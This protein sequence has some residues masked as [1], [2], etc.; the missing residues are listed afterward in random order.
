MFNIEINNEMYTMIKVSNA[1]IDL[2]L[3][4][5]GASI[6]SLKAY[7]HEF[8]LSPDDKT[9]FFNSKGYYGKTLGPIAGRYNTLDYGYKEKNIVLHGNENGLSFK[10]FD[11]EIKVN[12]S[13]ARV[14]FTYVMNEK[15]KDFIGNNAIF[16]VEYIL[17]H[18]NRLKVKHKIKAL[19][20]TYASMSS[21]LYFCLKEKDIRETY[22]N[23]NSNEVSIISDDFLINS[24]TNNLKGLN[25]KELKLLKN[26][27]QNNS[28]L[29]RKGHHYKNVKY[30]IIIKD[31]SYKIKINS[32][33]PDALLTI[34][35]LPCGEVCQ[36]EK[37]T[38]YRAYVIEP[39]I[40][41]DNKESLYIKKGETRIQTIEYNFKNEI[42]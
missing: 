37:E 27:L 7:N 12:N 16:I 17:N 13:Y 33:Y 8:L 18:S 15:E 14:I 32:T 20:N 5:F 38:K 34:D 11:Y 4:S 26:E 2:I 24:Y 25:F 3:S 1:D 35:Q 22:L 21:H 31:K 29:L 40:T 19:E 23:L 10:N 30:P 39:E 41:P 6:Y 36:N 42:N 28:P 9:R